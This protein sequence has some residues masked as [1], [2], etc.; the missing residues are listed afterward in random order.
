M[1]KV[2]N[3]SQLKKIA[4]KR[5]EG[6]RDKI[7]PVEKIWMD[8]AGD[9]KIGDDDYRIT[10]HA[11]GQ[12]VQKLASLNDKSSSGWKGY[13][14]ACEPTLRAKNFNNWKQ[15]YLEEEDDSDDEWLIRLKDD[16]IRGVLSD[17]YSVFD[18]TDVINV[19]SDNIDLT[20]MEL[21]GAHLSRDNMHVRFVR[22]DLK[23]GSGKDA[24]FAGWNLSNGEV[25]SSSIKVDF[26]IY[27]LICTN[28][29]MGLRE[30]GELFRQRHAGIKRHDLVAGLEEA[31]TIDRDKAVASLEKLERLKGKYVDYDINTIFKAIIDNH[32]PINETVTKG[33]AERID[34]YN[35]YTSTLQPDKYSIIS[36]ITET[37]RDYYKGDKRYDIE[38]EAGKLLD[39]NSVLDRNLDNY[40][41]EEDIINNDE[42]TAG[43]KLKRLYERD[44]N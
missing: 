27:Q 18:N 26:L 8:S 40:I 9:I 22:R 43:E 42:L 20:K 34:N 39:D 13:F 12:I 4:R 5:D 14:K 2:K 6:K 38:K 31:V 25:G 44:S 28:G 32:K 30:Y 3:M 1:I 29:M 41:T 21:K 24:L 15:K 19:V 16:I 35:R 17:R 33:A 7:V 11:L 37:A 23:E 10:D 36:S